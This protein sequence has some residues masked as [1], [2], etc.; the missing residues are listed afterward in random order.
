MLEISHMP[1]KR[2]LFRALAVAMAVALPLAGVTLAGSSASAEPL[3]I[4]TS[5]TFAEVARPSIYAQTSAGAWMQGGAVDPARDRLYLGDTQKNSTPGLSVLNL[6]DG[7]ASTIPLDGGIYASDTAVSPVDGTVYVVHNTADGFVSVVDPAAEYSAASLPPM[8]AVGKNSQ[9]VEVGSDGR[10]YVINFDDDSISVLGRADGADRLNVIQTLLSVEASGATSAIDNVRNLLFVASEYAQTITV[11]DTAAVPAAVVG[12][13]TVAHAPTG[14]SIDPR[15]GAAAVVTPEANTISWFASDDDWTTVALERTEALGVVDAD[16]LLPVSVDVRPD[17]TALVVT[18]VFPTETKSF[19]SVVPAV[20]TPTNPVRTIQV[21]N[22]AFGGVLDPQPGGS[23]YVPNSGNGNVSILADVTL[24]AVG[25]QVSFGQEAQAQATLNRADGYPI[26]GSIAF[27]DSASASLGTAAIGATGTA[28]LNLGARSVGSVPFTAAVTTPA[29]VALSA[30]AT[31]STVPVSTTTAAVIAP[32]VITEGDSA[33]VSVTVAAAHGTLPTGTVTL[34]DGTN[35]VGSAT[36]V[37]GSATIELSDLAAGTSHLTASYS[38][39]ALHVASTSAG[40][41][42]AVHARTATGVLSNTNGKVGGKLTINVSGF[43]PHETVNFELHSDPVALGSIT[44]DGTGSGSFTFSVPKVSPGTHTV[45][46]VGETSGR[47]T[48]TPVV[49]AA[50][51][52]TP[53]TGTGV[54]TVSPGTAGLVSTGGAGPAAALSA[55]LVL[56]L[57][58]SSLVIWRRRS[59]RS[60][61][62]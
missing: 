53:G 31:V 3:P 14:I 7:T 34:S 38:G 5:S 55:G 28:T 9:K 47:I 4:S 18:Q 2:P 25:S 51:A 43:V 42:L 24:T 59:R 23:F 26:T 48:S 6:Q 32:A 30:A 12:T 54:G 1:A 33:S 22:L 35:E 57:L 52:V 39:D 58:G 41:E 27:T 49:I 19:V 16:N 15:T 60:A 11:I 45:V 21:G 13:F 61:E 10:A 56:M 29:A 46:A 20:V 17:G 37:N 40:V 44:V 36:L 8:V 50:A 62:A